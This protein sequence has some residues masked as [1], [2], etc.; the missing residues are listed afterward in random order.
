MSAATETPKTP[1]GTVKGGKLPTPT[2]PPWSR[3]F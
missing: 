3:S 1:G 2:I